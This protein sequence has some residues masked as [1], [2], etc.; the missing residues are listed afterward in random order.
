MNK[1]TGILGS[2]ALIVG[3][4]LM[5][6]RHLDGELPSDISL[7]GGIAIG[8]FLGRLQGIKSNGGWS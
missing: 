1:K 6:Q 4:L 3:G 2:L 5:Y 7:F 8:Y